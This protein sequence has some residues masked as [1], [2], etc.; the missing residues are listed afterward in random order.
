MIKTRKIPK[1]Q[2]L[3]YN[4]SEEI[5]SGQLVFVLHDDQY[6]KR[7]NLKKYCRKVLKITLLGHKSALK[8]LER[9]GSKE[10]E[11]GRPAQTEESGAGLINSS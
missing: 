7:L 11:N 6:L 8:S 9:L 5:D 10:K 4:L 3:A 1:I 2:Y